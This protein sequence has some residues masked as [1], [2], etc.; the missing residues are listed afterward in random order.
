MWFE[1]GSAPGGVGLVRKILIRSFLVLCVVF[2]ARSGLKKLADIQSFGA[3]FYSGPKCL[4]LVP[5]QDDD[6]LFMNPDIDHHIA[7]G[8][9]V[10]SVFFTAGDKLKSAEY[11]LQ[12][13]DG[14]KAAY[15]YMAQVENIWLEDTLEL[16]GKKLKRFTLKQAPQV[17]LI[18]L[19]LPDGIDINKGEVTLRTIWK[20]DQVIIYTKDNANL[21]R[22]GE[23]IKVIKALIASYKPSVI[24]YIFPGSH[25]DHQY[26]AKFA[27]RAIEGRWNAFAVLKYRDYGISAAKANL[28]R[29]EAYRKWKVAQEYGKYDDSFPKHGNEKYFKRYAKWCQRQYYYEDDKSFEARMKQGSA[30]RFGPERFLEWRGLP[31]GF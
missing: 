14:I 3:Y 4:Y 1:K 30:K 23:L 6:L 12:R 17:Q 7:K 19:R 9:C 13:E 21:Y 31:A 2:I 20:Y 10:E 22:Q 29:V 16:A 28:N 8:C 27:E 24:G 5:H 25:I 11:W 18:F 26:V 15:A